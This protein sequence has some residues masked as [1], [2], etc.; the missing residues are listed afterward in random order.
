[1][2]PA[3]HCPV[4]IVREVAEEEWATL[5]LAAKEQ[6]GAAEEG[7]NPATLDV[8]GGMIDAFQRRVLDLAWAVVAE[9]PDCYLAAAGSNAVAPDR[10]RFTT[11]GQAGD[12]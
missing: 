4:T 3:R 9:L 11:R 2:T 6:L 5:R 10:L 7:W 1:M 8:D 12:A